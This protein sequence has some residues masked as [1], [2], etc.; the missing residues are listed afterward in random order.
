ML[1]LGW[2]M[3]C[4]RSGQ[5]G[6]G[7]GLESSREPKKKPSSG[8]SLACPGNPSR[9]FCVRYMRVPVEVHRVEPHSVIQ[10]INRQT[11]HYLIIWADCN[12]REAFCSIAE[13]A[14]IPLRRIQ[15]G[16]SHPESFIRA[17]RVWLTVR[18]CVARL[19]CLSISPG[20]PREGSQAGLTVTSRP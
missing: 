18:Y 9:R 20:N 17:V 4:Y 19:H 2:G 5:A 14:P 6:T 3:N 11:A 15:I 13:R 7:D 16:G 10:A 8:P 12:A 1:P